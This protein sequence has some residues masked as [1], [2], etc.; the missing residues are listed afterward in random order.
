M[1]AKDKPVH[2]PLSP[3]ES[4]S[5]SLGRIEI[6]NAIIAMTTRSSMSVNALFTFPCLT[7]CHSPQNR[8][9]MAMNHT[10]AVHPYFNNLIFEPSI[11]LIPSEEDKRGHDELTSLL[12]HPSN[13]GQ[14]HMAEKK[15]LFLQIEQ[16][17]GFSQYD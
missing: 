9:A 8:T 2:S 7:I 16:K 10:T 1:S 5:L 15:H 17:P 4:D 6:S 14:R 11:I 3:E 12:L 13:T